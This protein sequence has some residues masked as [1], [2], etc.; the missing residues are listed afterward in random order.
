MKREPSIKHKKVILPERS[1]V[2]DKIYLKMQAHPENAV[3]YCH[4]LKH[5]G[6]LSEKLLKQHQCIQKQCPLLEKYEDNYFWLRRAVLKQIK[7]LNKQTHDFYIHLQQH[8]FPHIKDN[9]HT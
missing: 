2:S 3:A 7:K 4:N 6:Y 8:F 5:L 1:P 9:E